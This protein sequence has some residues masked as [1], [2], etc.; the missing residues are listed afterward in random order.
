MKKFS[1]ICEINLTSTAIT[2]LTYRFILLLKQPF[3]TWKA[4]DLGLIDEQGEL[5][6]KPKTKEEKEALDGLTNL[7][8]KLKKILVK[9]VKSEKLI[10][11][12]VTMYLLRESSNEV[13][14][15]E[16]PLNDDETKLLINILR[17]VDK[18]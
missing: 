7:V 17:E 2:F 15:F 10:S 14:N 3:K 6:K 18:K 8:R 11:F 12:L 1:E 5:I 4:Y 9:Y 13:P 16:N